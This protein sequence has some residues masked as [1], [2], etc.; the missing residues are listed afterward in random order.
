MQASG[1]DLIWAV[2]SYTRPLPTAWAST[3]RGSL[4]PGTRGPRQQGKDVHG[5]F[6]AKLWM[7][8]GIAFC[9]LLLTEAVTEVIWLQGEGAQASP[10][11]RRVL[12]AH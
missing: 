6:M 7:S 11:Y 1:W 3:Q 12:V 10:G 8:H 9:C 5:I 2:S 4:V